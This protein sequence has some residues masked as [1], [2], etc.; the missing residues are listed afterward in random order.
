M[1]TG[2]Q[3]VD[4]S[5]LFCLWRRVEDS[6]GGS[7]GRSNKILALASRQGPGLPPEPFLSE[8]TVPRREGK[9]VAWNTHAISQF[10]PILPISSYFFPFLSTA[11]PGILGPYGVPSIPRHPIFSHI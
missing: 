5:D 11:S 2:R 3:Y 10:F 7:E 4:R 8:M 6:E 9:G 1:G